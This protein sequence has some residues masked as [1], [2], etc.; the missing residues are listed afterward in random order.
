MATIGQTAI[1]ALKTTN[2]ADAT[3]PKTR[4]RKMRVCSTS[5]P[6]GPTPP[7]PAA[8]GLPL[9]SLRHRAALLLSALGSE[10]LILVG[11][12]AL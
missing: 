11:M 2:T 1:A 8:V 5:R 4:N 6:V 9:D 3:A 7:T 10:K 12:G